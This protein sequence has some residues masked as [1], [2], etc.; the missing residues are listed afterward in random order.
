LVLL[1]VRARHRS[2]K[3]ES[4][5]LRQLAEHTLHDIAEETRRIL[6]DR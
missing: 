3:A 2:R 6:P 4:S 1:R 5:S